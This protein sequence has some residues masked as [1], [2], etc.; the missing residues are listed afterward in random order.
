MASSL[1]DSDN[2][3]HDLTKSVTDE[4]ITNTYSRDTPQVW[5]GV[6]ASTEGQQVVA[7]KVMIPIMDCPHHE[8]GEATRRLLKEVVSYLNLNLA[9]FIGFCYEEMQGWMHVPCLI[10]PSPFYENGLENIG[11]DHIKPLKPQDAATLNLRVTIQLNDVLNGL[12]YLHDQNIVH[13]NLKPTNIFIDDQGN[14]VLVG[15]EL[16]PMPWVRARDSK[17]GASWDSERYL[18][19][20]LLSTPK[21]TLS[22]SSDVWAAGMVGLQILSGNIPFVEYEEIGEVINTLK[23]KKIPEEAHYPDIPAD[24]WSL[25]LCCWVM[26]PITRP[27]VKKI[28]EYF[29]FLFLALLNSKACDHFRLLGSWLG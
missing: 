23:K 20:E 4:A 11:N 7:V 10:T 25:F 15:F 3:A 16:T 6:Y 26:D 13:G 2:T 24:A 21:P 28:L 5:K 1:T 19:P 22:Y 14:A 17:M 18:A 8:A 9:Q 12:T 29:E 27:A